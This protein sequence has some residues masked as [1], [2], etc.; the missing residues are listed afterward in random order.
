MKEMMIQQLIREAL[1]SISP[2][3]TN[4]CGAQQANALQ[5]SHINAI[6]IGNAIYLQ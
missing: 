2:H 6:S 5:W 3:Q 1:S 4:S